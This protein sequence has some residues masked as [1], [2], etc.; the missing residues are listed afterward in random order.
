MHRLTLPRKILLSL[1]VVGAAGSTVGAGTYA[2]FNASSSNEVSITTGTVLLEATKD[3]GTDLIGIGSAC[4]STESTT[5]ENHETGCQRLIN[6]EVQRPGDVAFADLTL[7]NLGNLDADLFVQASQACVSSSAGLD[8]FGGGNA[9]TGT[10]MTIQQY[11]SAADRENDDTTNGACWYGAGA[12]TDTCSFAGSATLQSFSTDHPSTGAS[13][14]PM[15]AMEA[16]GARYL[17]ISVELPENSNNDLQG[18]QANFGFTWSL[19]QQT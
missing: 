19:V 8:Y 5:D 15:G 2:S 13:P 4:F 14:L 10:R 9:C 3:D 16:D 17:R 7:V 1:M 18:V 12:L 6:V 11:A